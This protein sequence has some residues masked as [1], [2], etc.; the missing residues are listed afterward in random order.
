[1]KVLHTSDWHLGMTLSDKKRFDESEKFLIWLSELIR[2]EQVD[3]LVVSGD[4]FDTSVP[5][6]RAQQLYYSFLA[7]LEDCSAVIT[8]GNHDSPSL[9]SASAAVLSRMNI[10]VVSSVYG[11]EPREEVFV[12][13]SRS[14]REKIIVCAV[15]YLREGDMMLQDAGDCVSQRE[16]RLNKAVFAHYE[17]VLGYAAA[18]RD[19]LGPEIPLLATGHLY[20]AGSALSESEKSLYLGRFGSFDVSGLSEEIDYF[21]LGHLHRRQRVAGKE[22][23]R[24]SGAPLAMHF[25]ESGDGKSVSLVEFTARRC[26]VRDIPVPI[27]RRLV[28]FEGDAG[29]L[30]SQLGALKDSAVP[31]WIDIFCPGPVTPLLKEELTEVLLSLGREKG[32]FEI[33][34]IVA[35]DERKQSLPEPSLDDCRVEHYEVFERR[36]KQKGVEDPAEAAELR[37]LYDMLSVRLLER[38]VKEWSEGRLHENSQ[39]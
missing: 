17:A 22:Q 29:S 20:A 1:M 15:P 7:G 35:A 39:S 9:L 25:G 10:R 2:R 14:G 27:W 37:N 30:R 26:A 11:L 23:Y 31:V 8:A 12:I 16:E 36:L 19:E 21:A 34:R 33:L 4:I 38:D 28:R 13:E 6:H 24:Y 32:Y 18:L 3:L 5:S